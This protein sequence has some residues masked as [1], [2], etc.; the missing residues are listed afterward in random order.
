MRIFAFADD[1]EEKKIEKKKVI[2]APTKWRYVAWLSANW[3]G[4]QL[5]AFEVGP[6]RGVRRLYGE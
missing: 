3:T 4:L 1:R 6:D 5:K 2:Y